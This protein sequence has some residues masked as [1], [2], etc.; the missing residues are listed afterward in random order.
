MSSP[1]IGLIFATTTTAASRGEIDVAMS[2]GVVP[3]ATSRTAPSGSCTRTVSA[4]PTELMRSFILEL[5]HILFGHQLPT[6]EC[7][8]SI[9]S[10]MYNPAAPSCSLRCSGCP[11]GSKDL[12]GGGI[13]ILG[14]YLYG[15][16]VPQRRPPK[17]NERY[18]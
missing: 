7:P 12:T 13:S 16:E 11:V 4:V 3:E 6:G 5:Q 14:S 8:T 17:G 2:R 9:H 18:A 15:K 10:L 1:A